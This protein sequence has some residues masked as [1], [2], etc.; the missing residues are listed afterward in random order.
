VPGT[1]FENWHTDE[2]FERGIDGIERM[3][4]VRDDIRGRVQQLS[5]QLHRLS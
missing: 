3:R 4:L 5:E 1:R 2:P